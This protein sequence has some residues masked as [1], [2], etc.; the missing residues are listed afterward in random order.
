MARSSRGSRNS[1]SRSRR[2]LDW[3]VNEDTYGVSS[4]VA[5][6]PTGIAALPLTYP[7]MMV[8]EE[9]MGLPVTR[10][11][12]AWPEGEKQFVKAVRG[13]LFWANSQWGMGAILNL[14]FRIVKKPIDWASA[15]AITDATY[16]LSIDTYANERFA[17]EFK[18]MD[19]FTGGEAMRNSLVVKATVNQWLEPDEALFIFMENNSSFTN[20]T[21]VTSYL[22]TL[23][24]ADS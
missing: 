16:T 14:A 12:H 9:L 4:A 1:S 3:V 22:R 15:A 10:G 23:M 7:R 8:G 18:V 11:G 17:W 24:L 5:I 6:P 21:T 19:A 13:Q 20:N 2:K